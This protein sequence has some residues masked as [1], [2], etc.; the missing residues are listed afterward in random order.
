M[1]FDAHDTEIAFDGVDELTLRLEQVSFLG[2]GCANLRRFEGV[3]GVGKVVIC[4]S[5]TGFEDYIEWLK[6]AMLSKPGTQV[7]GFKPSD[8]T[9]ANRLSIIYY[10]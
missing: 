6:G 9:L 4:G 2:V 3:R 1:P 8:Q 10:A 5:T 7:D